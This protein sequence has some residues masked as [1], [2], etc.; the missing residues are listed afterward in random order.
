MKDVPAILLVQPQTGGEK[1]ALEKNP[2]LFHHHHHPR[3]EG[4]KEEANH[5]S[6]SDIISS[7]GLWV[8]GLEWQFFKPMTIVLLGN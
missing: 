5:N 3:K 4:R 7:V 8:R 6:H 1:R 2:T